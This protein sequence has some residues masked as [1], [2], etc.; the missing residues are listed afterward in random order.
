MEHLAPEGT[1]NPAIHRFYECVAAKAA[2]REDDA[3]TMLPALA[4]D[5]MVLETL[6]ARPQLLA[7]AADALAALPH[8]FSVKEQVHPRALLP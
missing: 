8:A 1:A 3:A 5:T 2:G 6:E 7:R 4:A